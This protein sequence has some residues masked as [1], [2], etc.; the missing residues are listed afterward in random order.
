MSLD[1]LDQL[2]LAFVAHANSRELRGVRSVR[3]PLV[4]E[5]YLYLSPSL[6]F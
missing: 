4:A 6:S 1:L 5:G 3:S 2:E